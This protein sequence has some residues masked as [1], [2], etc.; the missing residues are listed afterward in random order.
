MCEGWG[1]LEKGRGKRPWDNTIGRGEG[2]FERERER[3]VWRKSR[4]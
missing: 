1:H 3:E 4:R 2:G